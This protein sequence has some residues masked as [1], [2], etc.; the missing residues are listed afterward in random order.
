MKK[1][2]K[3]AVAL[4]GEEKVH[5]IEE[6]HKRFM[7]YWLDQVLRYTI[8]ACREDLEFFNWIQTDQSVPASVVDGYLLLDEEDIELVEQYDVKSV[9]KEIEYSEDKASE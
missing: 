5:Q 7:D 4:I 3:D 8:G 9:W 6:V 1:D 2:R